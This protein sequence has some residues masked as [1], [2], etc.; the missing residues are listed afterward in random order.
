MTDQRPV[1]TTDAGIAAASDEFSQTAGPNGPLLLQ[2]HYLLPKMA[3]FN[4]ARPW[5]RSPTHPR[6]APARITGAGGAP[7]RRGPL[8]LAVAW[9]KRCSWRTRPIGSST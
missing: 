8:W 3:Q 5:P 1:T 7:F 4:R 6:S 9:W 2:D